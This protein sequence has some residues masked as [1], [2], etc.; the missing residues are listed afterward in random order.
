MQTTPVS[1]RVK[2]L[3]WNIYMLPGFLGFGKNERSEA[4]GAVLSSGTYDVVVFQE[5]F[6]AAARHRI[7]ERLKSVYPYEAGPANARPFSVRTNSGLWIWSKYPIITQ[8]E[9]MFDA[10]YGIDGMSRKGGLLV[11]LD[12]D[13]HR[14]QVVATH[15]QN[16]GNVRLRQLQCAELFTKL[17]QPAQRP[18]VPQ[19]ICGDF[20]VDK[21]HAPDAYHYMLARLDAHDADV[22]E[23]SFSYDRQKNDLGVDPG[24]ARELIDFI[25][26]RNNTSSIRRLHY[27][28]KVFNQRWHKRHQD[29]SDHYAV[30]TELELTSG[31]EALSTI[32][33]SVSNQLPEAIIQTASQ[34]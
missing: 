11:E 26:V 5:A 13:G 33:A 8:Q 19:I 2:V 22:A 29:L 23:G 21:Y 32:S 27:A 16:A 17:L 24:D 9:I 15:L 31:A 30:E 14:V 3:S 7:R 18:G 20:N 4:I 10:R 6:Y 25:L 28:I 1:P 34:P 12:V